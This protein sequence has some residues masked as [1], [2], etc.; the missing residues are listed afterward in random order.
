MLLTLG[1]YLTPQ[2]TVALQ[3][4]FHPPS[5][6]EGLD[7]ASQRISV[8]ASHPEKTLFPMLN[9]LEGIDI[10]LSA[11]QFRKAY[12]PMLITVDGIEIL[13]S[14]AH[15]KNAAYPMLLTPS[16]IEIDEILVPEKAYRSISVIL[17]GILTEKSETHS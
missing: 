5:H 12:C 10:G 13:L 15:L 8:S 14:A 9:T 17:A 6:P 7:A 4:E 2:R 16:G 3:L 11:A 1:F